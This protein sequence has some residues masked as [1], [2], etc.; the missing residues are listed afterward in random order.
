M[1]IKP[2]AA[3]PEGQIYDAVICSLARLVAEEIRRQRQPVSEGESLRVP[4]GVSVHHVH[5]SRDHVEALFGP[6]YRLTPIRDLQPGQYAAKESVT[7]AG[8]RGVLQNVRVLGPPRERTQ[9][10][11]SR[12]DAYVLG[13]DPPVKDSGDLGGTPGVVMIG[14]RQAI[15]LEEGL[16]LSWRHIH[17]PPDTAG[18]W[19]LKGRDLVRVR[20]EGERRVIFDRVLIRVSP[21]YRL[22]M[23]IDTDEANAAG[24]RNGDHV[25]LIVEARGSV[26]RGWEN[27]GKTTGAGQQADPSFPVLPGTAAPAMERPAAGGSGPGY[28]QCGGVGGRRN[29]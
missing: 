12:S 22:E 17:M 7:L 16:V 8:P 25:Q 19:G 5:L 2:A 15:Y 13:L 14:P 26:D 4:V 6:G 10:E 23:H 3:S 1:T 11:I 27:D 29:R 21:A 20:T 24:L 18:R 28:G 9:V